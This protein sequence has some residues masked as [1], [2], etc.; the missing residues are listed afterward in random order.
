MADDAARREAA[1][2]LVA[3]RIEAK[4]RRWGGTRAPAP[5]QKE[6]KFAEFAGVFFWPLLRQYDRGTPTLDLL[7][8]DAMML[9]RMIYTLAVVVHSAGAATV[10]PPM[11]NA[12]IEVVLT[13]R[14]HADILVK[15]AIAFSL[16][17][18]F[19]AVPAEL[20]MLSMSAELREAQLWL[21]HTYVL[22][23]S[24]FP[25]D[26]ISFSSLSITQIVPLFTGTS[27]T[28]TASAVAWPLPG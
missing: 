27:T 25:V 11:A 3:S 21:E 17:V 1:R 7:G 16:V 24:C 23:F 28:R 10:V 20:L 2:Q 18:V 19:G 22:F 12:L 9:G 5:L 6:N 4:T 15:R 13:L 14:G 8:R 26:H